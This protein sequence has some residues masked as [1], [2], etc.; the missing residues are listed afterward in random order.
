MPLKTNGFSLVN[1]AAITSVTTTGWAWLEP[2][3]AF[4]QIIATLVAIVTGVYAIK[5]Y[6][7]K[8]NDSETED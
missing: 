2:I 8:R 4:L 6:R 7:S 3:G 1:I 5:Y